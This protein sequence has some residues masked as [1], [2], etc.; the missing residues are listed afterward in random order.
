MLDFACSLGASG[1]S[2]W[3]AEV[4][5]EL[6]DQATQFTLP[7]TGDEAARCYR[8]C[9]MSNG[10]G[11][12]LRAAQCYADAIYFTYRLPVLM[13][14]LPTLAVA[15]FTVTSISGAAQT[16][17]TFSVGNTRSESTRCLLIIATKTGHGLTDATLR[18]NYG[19]IFDAEA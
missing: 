1:N 8:Y 12:Y 7:L 5:L 14:A 3:L 19:N 11:D 13:Q 6:G 9:Y 10:D 4:K 18:V 2:V 17:F 15:N 16:G